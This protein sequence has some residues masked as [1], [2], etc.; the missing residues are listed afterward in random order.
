MSEDFR[1]EGRGFVV[2]PDLAPDETTELPHTKPT[3][4]PIT[5][6]SEES[7]SEALVAELS[8]RLQG[9]RIL[10][11]S[12]ANTAAR[13]ALREELAR[14]VA[15]AQQLDA[16]LSEVDLIADEATEAAFHD[17]ATAPGGDQR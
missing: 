5:A 2:G 12:R 6:S 11:P 3:P 15:T 7:E 16:H 8:A 14:M 10:A 13:T 9:V 17:W 1:Y 4:T